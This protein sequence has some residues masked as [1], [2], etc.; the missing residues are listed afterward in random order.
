ME[1]WVSSRKGIYFPTL[2]NKFDL[3]TKMGETVKSTSKTSESLSIR[4]SSLEAR[5]CSVTNK[6]TG[7][8]AMMKNTCNSTKGVRNWL[9]IEI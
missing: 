4:D 7:L 3:D 2:S 5:S 1:A 9:T 6:I 8:V